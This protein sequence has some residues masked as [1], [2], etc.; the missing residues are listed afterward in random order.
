MEGD[1]IGLKKGGV[2]LL[3]PEVQPFIFWTVKLAFFE[4][5]M[6]FCWDPK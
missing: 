5:C 1:P 6:E 3:L 4:G 2:G